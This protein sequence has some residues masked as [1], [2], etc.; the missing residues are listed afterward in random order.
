MD[1]FL[2]ARTIISLFNHGNV[3]ELLKGIE[4]AH[5][6]NQSV[7]MSALN[8]Q[9]LTHYRSELKSL[10]AMFPVTNWSTLDEF[11][12]WFA[13]SQFGVAVRL[14]NMRPKMAYFD[15][16]TMLGMGDISVAK[17]SPTELDQSVELKRVACAVLMLLIKDHGK[18]HYFAYSDTGVSA[19]RY[20]SSVLE[21]IYLFAEGQ[22]SE[23]EFFAVVS[24][25]KTPTF[26]SDLELAA[27]LLIN[28]EQT[29]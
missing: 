12:V 18:A 14:V 13:T 20:T 28:K 23:K 3:L 22:T 7:V 11:V 8:Q 5:K 2:V 9:L 6:S 10:V 29:Q 16:T 15:Y 26:Y 19:A 1:A 4:A 21:K 24:V 25:F 27:G 17:V